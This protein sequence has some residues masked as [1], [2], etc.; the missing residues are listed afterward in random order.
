VEGPTG[1][2]LVPAGAAEAGHRTGSYLTDPHLPT[3]TI[4]SLQTLRCLTNKPAVTTSFI[5]GIV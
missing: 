1:F 3:I 2:A 4:W 5:V